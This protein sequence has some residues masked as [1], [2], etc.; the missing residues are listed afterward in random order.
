MVLTRNRY[1]YG[2][3]W[4]ALQA[5]HGRHCFAGKSRLLL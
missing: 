2:R 4:S 3:H 5:R 1:W